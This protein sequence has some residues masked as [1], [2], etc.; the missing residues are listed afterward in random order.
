MQLASRSLEMILTIPITVVL[1]GWPMPAPVAQSG[2]RRAA[3][4][5]ST[6]STT[7]RRS[8]ESTRQQGEYAAPTTPVGRSRDTVGAEDMFI[9]PNLPTT[10]HTARF[11]QYPDGAYDSQ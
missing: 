8:Q 11:K 7:Q 10:G 6:Q 4:N 5:P 1:L 2:Q 9:S 3:S